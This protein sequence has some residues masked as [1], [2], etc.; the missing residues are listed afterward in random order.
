MVCRI[1]MRHAES[2]DDILMRAASTNT[3]LVCIRD[4]YI[5]L[6]K[7]VQS[8]GDPPG[9]KP[10]RQVPAASKSLR[11]ARRFFVHVNREKSLTI[12]IYSVY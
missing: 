8:C 5:A 12:K 9:I 6:Y 10:R 1:M 11:F 2:D 3:C 4:S 7:C